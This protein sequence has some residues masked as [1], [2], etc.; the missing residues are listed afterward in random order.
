MLKSLKQVNNTKEK[1]T[2]MAEITNSD[3]DKTKEEEGSTMF[4]HGLG[5]EP[6]LR[7]CF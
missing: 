1:R 2:K 5:E 7:E 4:A 3:G 6:V